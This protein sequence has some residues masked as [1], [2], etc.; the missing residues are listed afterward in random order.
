[1]TV[2]WQ[3]R[4]DSREVQGT[5][6][7]K[8]ASLFYIIKTDSSRHP[9]DFYIG[10][11]G[12]DL[13]ALELPKGPANPMSKSKAALAPIPHYVTADLGMMGSSN[14][15]LRV[16]A[17]TH[18]NR[19]RFTLHSS[20]VRK[21]AFTRTP[22]DT[23]KWAEGG[24]YFINC[25]RRMFKLDGYVAMDRHD[26][27]TG[28]RNMAQRRRG[29]GGGG[30]GD[31]M[32]LEEIGPEPQQ[33]QTGSGAATGQQR[34]GGGGGE[35]GASKKDAGHTYTTICK[36]SVKSHSNDWPWMVFHLLPGEHKDTSLEERKLRPE[37]LGEPLID[38]SKFPIMYQSDERDF[39][40]LFGDPTAQ[41]TT[42]P[43]I[44]SSS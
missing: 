40:L 37:E 31:G 9:H 4:E 39:Q 38:R 5:S 8:D 13:S 42:N 34:E 11:V 43:V 12:N 22:V 25:S 33:Q 30:G 18:K 2:Y 41:A 10:Y 19:A 7:K 35:G 6:E 3:V 1:V 44:D 36:K 32:E 24:G 15:P 16:T 20:T 17:G 27:P 23:D 26:P 21:Y 29:G 28:G 14:Q